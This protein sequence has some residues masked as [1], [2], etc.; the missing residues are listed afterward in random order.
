M[1][2]ANDKLA[3]VRF[4]PIFPL[5]LVLFPN[6]PLPLH[7]F[8]PRYRKMLIDIESTGNLFGIVYFDQSNELADRP[9]PDSIG[10]AAEV[11]N[12]EA[13]PDGRSN[14]STFG[15]RRYRIIEYADTDEDYLVAEVEFISDDRGDESKTEWLAE[16]V[17]KLFSRIVRAANEMSGQTSSL[18]DVPS[19]DPESLSFLVAAA[20][21]FDIDI[22]LRMLRTRSTLARLEELHEILSK[23][24]DKIEESAHIGKISRTNGHS[25]KKI[26]Y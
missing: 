4:L 26:D 13:M 10:C 25:K 6:E 2:D 7:I 1:A 23:A 8:E 9:E 14:I 16:H 19:R 22:K 20:F 5:P 12:V 15:I 18:A 3:G 24:V 11:V 17:R 21:S